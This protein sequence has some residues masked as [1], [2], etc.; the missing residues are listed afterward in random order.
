MTIILETKF[1]KNYK[2]LMVRV[3]RFMMMPIIL[4]ITQQVE[5][6]TQLPFI[7]KRKSKTSGSS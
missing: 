2:W 1:N 7:N 4:I 3:V 5:P 6:V